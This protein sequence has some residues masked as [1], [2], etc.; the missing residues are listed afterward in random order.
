MTEAM[1]TI[2]V[3]AVILVIKYFSLMPAHQH[4]HLFLLLLSFVRGR[5]KAASSGEAAAPAETLSKH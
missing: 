4:F 2:M 1:M 3:M 5:Q